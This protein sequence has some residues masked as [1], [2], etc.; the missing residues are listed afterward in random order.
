AISDINKAMALYAQPTEFDQNAWKTA[1]DIANNFATTSENH[2][3]NRE[4]LA[5]EDWRTAYQNTWYEQ[6][7]AQKKLEVADLQRLFDKNKLIDP[8]DTQAKIA[9]NQ[10]S[11]AE[12]TNAYTKHQALADSWKMISDAVQTNGGRMPTTEELFNIARANPNINP[13]LFANVANQ[14][15]NWAGNQARILAPIN[16]QVASAYNVLGG[17]TDTMLDN[18]GNL[19]NFNSNQVLAPNLTA[20]QQANLVTEQAMLPQ[21]GQN[22]R[23]GNSGLEAAKIRQEMQAE[24]LNNQAEVKANDEFQKWVSSSAYSLMPDDTG[25]FDQAQAR[26]TLSAGKLIYRNNPLVLARIEQLEREVLGS[27]NQAAQPLNLKGFSPNTNIF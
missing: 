19:V 13:A 2:R 6:G 23:T 21:W 25:Q 12:Q 1:F 11:A 3:K 17:I 7:A 8:S 27:N 10:A 5:T 22:I 14:Y 18:N 16:P 26:Q 4:N 24:R 15:Q 9:Q 20:E